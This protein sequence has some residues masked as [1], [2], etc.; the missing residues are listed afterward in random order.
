MPSK[1]NAHMSKKQYLTAT[2]L[3]ISAMTACEGNLSQVEALKQLRSE[4]QSKK[5]VKWK[6]VSTKF[7]ALYFLLF[8]R[9]DICPST[10]RA[11]CIKSLCYTLSS[12]ISKV[13]D[14]HPSDPCLNP[15]RVEIFK[16][17]L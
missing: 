11:L 3:L 16:Y 10:I 7:Q 15:C 12:I 6:I 17:L 14:F 5:Q 13:L 8:K 1:V 4:L 9:I 2:H